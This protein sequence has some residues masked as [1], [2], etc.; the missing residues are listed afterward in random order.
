MRL[1]AVDVARELIGVGELSARD[2]AI[3]W[4]IRLPRVA[5]GIVVGATLAVAGAAYQ[6]VFRNPLADPYLLGLSLIHI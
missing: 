1:P 2:H 6:A 4:D 3:L 5:M